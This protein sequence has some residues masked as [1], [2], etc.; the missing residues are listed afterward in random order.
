MTR[1]R[2]TDDGIDIDQLTRRRLLA[3]ASA[4]GIAGLAGCFGGGGGGSTTDGDG[5]GTTGSAET[6]GAATTTEPPEPVTLQVRSWGEGR[7]VEIN[8]RILTNYAESAPGVAKIEYAQTPFEQYSQ[9]LQTQFAGGNEPDVFYLI[10]DDAPKFM[11]NGALL[12]LDQYV[13]NADD[14]DLDGIYDEMLT[15]FTY[16]GTIYGIPKDIS[17]IGFFHNTA[18]LEEA[19]V[20]AP[21]T[22]SDVRAA[23]DAVKSNTDIEYPMVFNSQPRNTLVQLIWQNGGRVLTEDLS[24]CVVGS[25]EAIA[26]LDFLN[27][28]IEDDLAGLLGSDIQ[29]TWGAPSLGKEQTSMM[30]T[31][32]WT[33]GTLKS[34]YSDVYDVTDVSMTK[35]DGGS[36]ATIVFTTSWSASA[37]TDAKPQAAGLVKALTSEEGMWQWVK[38]GNALPARPA[39]L[40]K[41]FYDD[42]PLL[43][44]LGQLGDIGRPFLFGP[45][46]PTILSTL[47][48]EAEATLTGDKAPDTAM[49]DAERQINDAL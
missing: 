27:G 47:M 4:T 31:G 25:S 26:A 36:Q 23:A 22:W 7:E 16:D 45:Q 38:T 20:E 8:R 19:G 17:P 40:E 46:T 49:K 12:P 41:D 43:S 33:I 1:Q 5:G 15:A 24:E 42:R 48:T 44:N 3:G 18:H 6:D 28:M 32:A 37:N 14:Y 30:M 10:A 2:G 34:D 11:R 13:R 29:G 35:A 21:E 9:K 39:L